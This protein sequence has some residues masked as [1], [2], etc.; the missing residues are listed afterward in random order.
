MDCVWDRGAFN[1]ITQHERKAYVKHIKPFLAPDFKY[2]L[3][4]WEFDEDKPRPHLMSRGDGEVIVQELY[5]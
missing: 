4:F 2:L 1:S 5:G 3:M